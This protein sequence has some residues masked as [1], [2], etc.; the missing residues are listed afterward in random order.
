MS[1]PFSQV[2]LTARVTP[3]AFQVSIP[4]EQLRDLH[5]LVKLSKMAPPTYEN[6]RPDARFGTTSEWLVE[7]RDKWMNDFDWK[8]C[9][10][11]INDFPQF[12]A[13]IEDIQ[14]HF[15]ALFSEKPDAVPIVLLH[16]WPGSFLEFLPL[17]QLF[18][19]EF[20]PS[21]LPYHLIVPS[22]PGYGFS[23]G[24]P[25]D[26]NYTSHDIAR[27][28]DTLMKDLGFE[29]GYVAQGGD[30]GSRVSR[31]LALDHASCKAAHLN[32]C[33]MATAPKGVSDENLTAAE[34]KGLARRQEFLTSGRAYALEHATR[35]STIGHIL[36]SSPL[37]LLAW[38]GEKFLT[39]VDEP[40]PTQTIL[41][42]V[43]LYWL[44]ETFPRAIYPYREQFSVSPDTDPLRY[45]QKPLGFSSFPVEL[46]PVPKS[47]IE[48]TGNLV[49]WREHQ[50]GGHF[51]A[52]EKPQELKADLTE[53]V[54]QIWGSI[55][56]K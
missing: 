43:S 25:V 17:L 47:W 20:T 18:R 52:L 54:E 41:E 51:A 11:R 35:P 55:G 37:A 4:Q 3:P 46:F 36:S 27:I 1:V 7:T 29:S 45:I 23:S 2:P 21:T 53:F 56:D 5:T 38:V 48:T 40:L 31:I 30:I 34:K 6:S 10:A 32:F 33:S 49:F 39:W 24:P 42:F 9:E 19:D 26:R 44:T 28:I 13:E 8:A 16:G 14:L 12:T 15:A 22:L 50:R